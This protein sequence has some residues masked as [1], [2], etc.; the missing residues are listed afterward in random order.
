MRGLPVTTRGVLLRARPS[1]VAI[2]VPAGCKFTDS[3][4]LSISWPSET[5]VT[6]AVDRLN[7]FTLREDTIGLRQSTLPKVTSNLRFSRKMTVEGPAFF[8][9]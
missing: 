7:Q 3:R 4:V 5:T 8:Q 2:L 6:Y 9:Y 1:V